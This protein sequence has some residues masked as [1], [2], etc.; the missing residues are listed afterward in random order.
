[1]ERTEV[2][3]WLRTEAEIQEHDRVVMTNPRMIRAAADMLEADARE[4][5]QL[6]GDMAGVRKDAAAAERAR[7]G[8]ALQAYIRALPRDKV[9][10]NSAGEGGIQAVWLMHVERAITEVC[11]PAP[12]AP[13]Y[14]ALAR[15]TWP[16]VVALRAGRQG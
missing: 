7:V 1:M 4:A 9:L 6:M 11:G 12:D 2:I 14:Q 5:D 3:A 13:D 15:T 10:V 8:A 16:P